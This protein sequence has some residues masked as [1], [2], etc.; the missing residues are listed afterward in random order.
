MRKRCNP[1]W[2]DEHM[3]ITKRVRRMRGEQLQNKAE[4]IMARVI[5]DKLGEKREGEPK[6]SGTIIK[7]K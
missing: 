5:V 1:G 3:W 7:D 6:M 4:Q 2:M